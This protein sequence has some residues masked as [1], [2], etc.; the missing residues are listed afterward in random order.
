MSNRL[1]RRS[2]TLNSWMKTCCKPLGKAGAKRPIGRRTMEDTSRHLDFAFGLLQREQACLVIKVQ[3][4]VLV[5][6]GRSQA[7]Y[8]Q[9]K[10][11]EHNFCS[12]RQ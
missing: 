2:W 3:T 4:L 1:S 9:F 5:E 6:T 11:K 8:T 10:G 12:L 7:G